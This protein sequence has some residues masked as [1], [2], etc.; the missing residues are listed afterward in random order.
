MSPLLK[1]DSLATKAHRELQH[2]T[3][4]TTGLLQKDTTQEQPDA[5]RRTG[6]EGKR[7]QSSHALSKQP[8]TE[9]SHDH[10][11]KSWDF[12]V[13]SDASTSDYITSHCDP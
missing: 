5:R 12:M 11:P 7:L 3:Q 1:L 8:L 10:Q 13:A 6:Q 2:L 9:P 4:W